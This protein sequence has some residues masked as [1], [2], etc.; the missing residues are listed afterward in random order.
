[1]DQG[2]P[3]VSRISPTTRWYSPRPMNPSS[4]LRAPIPISARSD[5]WRRF[6]QT[7]VSYRARRRVAS[8]SSGAISRS[9]SRPP[10]GAMVLMGCRASSRSEAPRGRRRNM[11][12]ALL[13]LGQLPP[14]PS[15]P[16]VLPG[17]DGAGARGASDARV[18][19]VVERVIGN[20]VGADVVPD[21]CQCPVGDRVQFEHA[22]V[23]L[24]TLALRNPDAGH[25]LLP[26][27]P[28]RPRI[29]IREGPAER[30]HLADPPAA[31]PLLDT[32]PERVE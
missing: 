24:I 30:L 6:R 28:G 21:L 11:Q 12:A 18:A 4:G 22:V 17:L 20:A 8:R 10:C 32:S 19:Q 3:L 7:G 2:R 1:M 25:R 27:K 23:G 15:G 31:L 14:P 5:S 26:A 9:I 29:A 13:V 16:D